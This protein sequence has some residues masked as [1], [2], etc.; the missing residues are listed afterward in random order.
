AAP[1]ASPAVTGVFTTSLID[2]GSSPGAYAGPS[3]TEYSIAKAI[4][5]SVALSPSTTTYIAGGSAYTVT[6][7]ISSAQQGVPIVFSLPTTYPTSTSFTSTLTPA[8]G[9]SNAVGALA[10]TWAPSN[11]ATDAAGVTVTVGT[12]NITS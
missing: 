8:S 10:T 3:I 6:A 5:T 4:F 1:A 9:T 11:K 7:T 12:G 2:G